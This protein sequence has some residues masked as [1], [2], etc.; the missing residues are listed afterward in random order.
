MFAIACVAKVTVVWAVAAIVAACLRRASAASRHFVWAA[1]VLAS[2]ALP[3]LTSMLPAWRS[4]TV[5]RAAAIFSPAG[6]RSLLQPSEFV[7]PMRIDAATST[8]HIV[9]LLIVLWAIGVIAFGIRLLVGLY[10]IQVSSEQALPIADSAWKRIWPKSQSLYKSAGKFACWSRRVPRRCRSPG[11][12]CVRRFCS[13]REHRTGRE[14]AAASF[15]AMNLRTSRAAIGFSK[16]VPKFRARFTGF[17]RWPGKLRRNCA[18][19]ANA[20]AMTSF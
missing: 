6:R 3:L 16:S 9:Q 13:L 8:F 10:R 11:D 19:K 5:A 14:N 1:A 18:T 17:I 2:L 12:C 4:T 7:A 15:C 20:P